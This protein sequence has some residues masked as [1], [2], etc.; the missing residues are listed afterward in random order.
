VHE[1]HPCQLS[2]HNLTAYQAPR[3]I[4]TLESIREGKNLA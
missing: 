4:A 3:A 1:M 2:T